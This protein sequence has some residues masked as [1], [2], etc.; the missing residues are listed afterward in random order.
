MV[1]RGVLSRS[2]GGAVT[3]V[4]PLTT[5]AEEIDRIVNTLRDALAE[6]TQ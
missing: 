2:L 4:P 6:C 3:I 5:T 1:K